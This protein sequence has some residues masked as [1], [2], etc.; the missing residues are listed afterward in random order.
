[1]TDGA[2]SENYAYDSFGQLQ[3]LIRVIDGISYEKRYEYNEAGQMTMMTYPSGKRVKM[4]RDVR[5]R[6]AATQKVDASGIVQEAYL[7]EVNY[8]VDGQV[9]GQRLGDGTTESFGYSNDR[10]QLTSQ[11]VTKGGG[12]LLSLN[13]GYGASAGQ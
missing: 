5:G 10:L 2:G 7:S 3:S 13:Y 9:G 11:T 8:R 12:T 4:G 1:V 6:V